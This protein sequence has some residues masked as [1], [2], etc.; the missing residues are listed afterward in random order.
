MVKI[1]QSKV[2]GTLVQHV[3]LRESHCSEKKL[4]SKNVNFRLGGPDPQMGGLCSQ[5]TGALY[6]DP[7][8][9]RSSERT[10]AIRTAIAEKIDFEEKK[11]APSSGK[12][13][14]DGGPRLRTLVEVVEY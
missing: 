1:T 3:K 4:R 10:V 13:V 12:T 14:H 5:R 11:S 7:K 9:A 2:H 6:R 8:E